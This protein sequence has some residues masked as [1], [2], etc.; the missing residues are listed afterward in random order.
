MNYISK[1]NERKH[2]INGVLYTSLLLGLLAGLFAFSGQADG[3]K[4]KIIELVS[5]TESNEEVE[6][7]PVATLPFH[8]VGN[9]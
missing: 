6:K 9:G 3:L 8:R 1:R 4:A 2:Q 5:P 7:I